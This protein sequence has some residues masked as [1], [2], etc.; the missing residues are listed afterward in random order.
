MDERWRRREREEVEKVSEDSLA[1]VATVRARG[2]G[3]ALQCLREATSQR[4]EGDLVEVRPDT[5]YCH[6]IRVFRP[7]FC[8]P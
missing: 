4:D 2:I 7:S 8:F 3:Y 6:R 1:L 5:F